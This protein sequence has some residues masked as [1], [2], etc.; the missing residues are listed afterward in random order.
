MHSFSRI[1]YLTPV[2]P[3]RLPKLMSYQRAISRRSVLLG[4]RL[5]GGALQFSAISG[6][7]MEGVA[8]V[9]VWHKV[10][11]GV[12]LATYTFISKP[13]AEAPLVF[14]GRIEEIK[15]PHLAI[16]VAR[17]AGLPL[18]IAGN[19]PAAHRAWFERQ[20]APHIDGDQVRFVGP[21]DDAQKNALLGSARALLMPILWDEP[22]GIV[23]AEAMAC[24]TP[25][26]GFRRGAVP[27]IVES[28]VTGFVV[29]TLEDMAA[30]V[31]KLGLI[32]RRAVRARVERLFSDDAVVEGYLE[33][34]E[35][36]LA[37]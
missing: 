11:N 24:G 29:Q 3:W 32:D 23:M 10:F 1:A 6:F 26:I 22:F 17:R 20:V 34:Y 15:G 2:L 18:V 9:G 19:V 8:D 27:E 28:G 7:L 35:R 37:P 16:E 5:S 25:V 30:A 33:V 31:N 12:P 14:L 4:H 21:V 36:M 13:G